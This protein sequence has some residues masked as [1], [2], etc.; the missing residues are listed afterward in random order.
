MTDTAAGIVRALDRP[1]GYEIINLGC[2]EPVL[3]ADFVKKI[4]AAAGRTTSLTDAPMQDADVSYTYAN[5][6]KARSLLG[7]QPTV[8]V[9]EGIA[10]FWDWYRQAVLQAG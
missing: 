1:L 7:Y 6:D 9:D 4:E 5:I 3:L 8:R 10:G 2:A